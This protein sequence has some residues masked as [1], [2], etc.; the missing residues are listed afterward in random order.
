MSK[1]MQGETESLHVPMTVKKLS[2]ELKTFY[3]S[4][5]PNGFTGESYQPFW[6]KE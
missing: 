6:E 3:K 5:N 2:Q 1:F 4:S